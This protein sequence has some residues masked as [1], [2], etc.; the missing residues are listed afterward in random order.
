MSPITK[1]WCG[2]KSGGEGVLAEKLGKGVRPASQNSY[3][4]YDQN[5]RFSPPYLWPNQKFDTLFMNWPLK[6]YPVSDLPYK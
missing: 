2:F 4:I 5:L 6:Q 1:L 3:P